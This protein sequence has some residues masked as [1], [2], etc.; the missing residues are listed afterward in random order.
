VTFIVPL[1]TF[2]QRR[3]IGKLIA[4]PIINFTEMSENKNHTEEEILKENQEQNQTE[5]TQT[6][7]EATQEEQI[8]EEQE[9][10]QT[11]DADK[12]YN[13]LNDKYLRLY[14]DFENFRKRTAKEKLDLITNGGESVIKDVITVLDDFERAINANKSNQDA[15]SIKEGF[16]LIYNK[17]FKVLNSKGLKPM[18]TNGEEFN[19]DIHEAVTKFPVQDEEQKGKVIDTMEKG[20]YLNEKV[21]RYAK[22]VVGE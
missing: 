10:N 18:E 5:E 12:K 1:L 2:L 21:I 3:Y 13:E 6:E 15:D 20:Y 4:I 16:E 8:A 19:S 14:S 7:E 22:V 11:D 9:G 17:L